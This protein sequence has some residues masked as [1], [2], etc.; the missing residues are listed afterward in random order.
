[1]NTRVYI[2]EENIVGEIITEMAYGAKVR[3]LLGGIQYE[4]WMSEDDYEV[5]DEMF[6]DVEEE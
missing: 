5:L 3:Y 4:V 6:F 2:Q 1:M